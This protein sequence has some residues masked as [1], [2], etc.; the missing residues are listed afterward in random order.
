[1]NIIFKYFDLLVFM[2]T[3]IIMN[4]NCIID[5]LFLILNNSKKKKIMYFS[6][7]TASLKNYNPSNCFCD[8]AQIK[9]MLFI[10]S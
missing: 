1:M 7:F 5:F 2:G 8:M 10:L 4:Y 6:A 3:K 9:F